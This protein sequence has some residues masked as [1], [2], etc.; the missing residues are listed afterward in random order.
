MRN[1]ETLQ[2]RMDRRLSFLDERPSCR[3]ALMRQIAQEEEPVMKKKLSTAL[4]F[5]LVL[6][7]LSVIALAAEL[8]LSPRVTAAR[9][10]DRALQKAYGV[11]EQ[12]QTFFGREE[13]ELPDGTVQITYTGAGAFEAPLGIYTVRVRNGRAAVSWSHD[14]E[15]T[16][17]GYEAEAWGPEQLRQMMAESN[18][19]ERRGIYSA[20]AEELYRKSHSGGLDEETSPAEEGYPERREAE[21][22][23]AMNARKLSEEELIRIA[24]AFIIESY[25]LTERQISLLELYTECLPEGDNSWY[26]RINGKNCFLVEYLL[27]EAP[28]ER[29][30]PNDKGWRKQ[31]SYFKIF[32]NVETGAIEQYEYNSGLGGEG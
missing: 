21:K 11:T 8:L 25:S 28:D 13:E 6:V 27:D 31:N 7:S 3:P 14:G 24:R 4:V 20:R 9:L 2:T 10:A 22:T 18:N 30:D 32:V 26:E 29:P 16:E 15:S 23:A 5:A 1:K 12:M 17:G 19:S